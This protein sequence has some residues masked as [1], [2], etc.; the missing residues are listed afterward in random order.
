MNESHGQK[1]WA[2][3]VHGGAKHIE[4]DEEQDNRSGI[5][6]AATVGAKILEDGGSALDAVEAAIRVL[7]DL[8]VFNAGRGSCLNEAGEIEMSSGLMDGSDL[9]VGAV[10]AIRNVRNPVRVARALLREREVL[11]VG[12][13]ASLF[14]RECGAEFASDEYLKDTPRAAAEHDT[15]GAVALDLDGNIAAGTSTGGLPGKRVGRVGDSPLAGAGFYAQN[16]VGGVSLSGDGESIIRVGAAA[17][18]MGGIDDLG[19]EVASTRALDLLPVV[20]GKDGD[21]GAIVIRAD[22][23]LG[24]HHNS[25]HFA[26]AIMTSDMDEPSAWLSKQEECNER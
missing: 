21:G 23:Q 26:V 20:G 12:D 1:H 15:V 8:P 18:I 3:I 9:S 2:L 19:P 22:G 6:A 4:R 25:S 16:G 11:L 7:E 13:G 17:R 24:W 10:G 5:A 14:A